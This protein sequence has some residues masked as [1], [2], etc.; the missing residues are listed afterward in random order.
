M[1]KSF[2]LSVSLVIASLGGMA[3][4]SGLG[5]KNAAADATPGSEAPPKVESGKVIF[6]PNST[7]LRSLH[8]EP[9]PPATNLTLTFAGRL[10]WN[11]NLTV[12]IF[13]PFGGRIIRL[14]SETGSHVAQGAPLLVL[15]SPD[16][17]QAQADARRAT[18]DLALAEKNYT[19]LQDLFFHGAAAAK[20]LLGAE[21][22]LARA[23]TEAERSKAKVTA[24]GLGDISNDSTFTLKSPI[25]GVVVEKN[26]NPG[27][28]V[29]PDQMLAGVERLAAPLLVITDPTQLWLLLDLTESD[30]SRLKEGQEFVIHLSGEPEQTFRGVLEYLSDGLDPVTRLVRARARV[31]NEARQ[32]RAEQLVNAEARL[33]LQTVSVDD[34]A[35]FL[36]G[37]RYYVFIEANPGTYRR[38]E[39]RLGRKRSGRVQ[40]LSGL[41]S[42]EPVVTDGA[43]LLNQILGQS[44]NL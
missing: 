2:R 44:E 8:I 3:L 33:E 29:R 16:F 27:Q 41:K 18:A 6:S 40:I 37:D 34:N 30:A 10:S 38:Q 5:C 12:R 7:Q 4:L 26:A 23:R 1:C 28:E 24:Y 13:S 39:V 15:A 20:D 11:E 22:D 25:A 21:T 19:R 9:T 17:G 14:Q 32:L 31:N 35:V 43:L 42:G 36:D